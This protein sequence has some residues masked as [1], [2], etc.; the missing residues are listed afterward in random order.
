MEI[1]EALKKQNIG[2]IIEHPSMARYT[3][4][5]V[6]GPALAMVFPNN[7]EELITLIRFLREFDV[8]YKIV[9]NGSNLIFGDEPYDG[10]II[11]LDEFNDLK[12]NGQRITVGAGYSMV[13]LA[14][15][16]SRMGFSGLEFAAGI[17]G[18]VGGAIY[19][20]AGAYQS[21]MGYI[22][23]D[24]K[25]LTPDLEVRTIYN[26]DLEFHYRTSFLQKNPGYICLEVNIRL[27][28]GDRNAIMEVIDDRKK[29]RLES[30]PLEYPCAGSVFRNPPNDYAGR[31]V[32]ELGYKGRQ[33]GG[34]MVS[35][36]HANFVI[37]Y[38]H[39][40]SNDIKTLIRE[41]QDKVQE[42]YGIELKVEQEFVE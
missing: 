9:G 40:T 30:Q 17:P 35:E 6:G 22:V 2:K 25:V 33:F 18:T 28:E 15:K 16:L 37:N 1:L 12:I 4:Y 21:D 11:K 34:A 14:L 38:H 13:K 3:T 29:R 41:I 36:K 31:L 20:N 8:K 39:A 19:M 24:I 23:T 42:N 5:Q 10:I 32:E 27:K 26:K 7:T